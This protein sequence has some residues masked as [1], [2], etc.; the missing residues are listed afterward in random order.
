MLLQA[1]AEANRCRTVWSR[2]LGFSTVIG[3][4]RHASGGTAVHL[5]AVQAQ[6]ALQAAGTRTYGDGASRTRSFRQSFLTAYATRIDQRLKR[7]TQRA[8]EAAGENRG[9]ALPSARSSGHPTRTTPHPGR[10][11]GHQTSPRV[12]MQRQPRL[13]THPQRTIGDAVHESVIGH[14]IEPHP[15]TADWAPWRPERA[16]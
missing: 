7:A 16:A 12:S 15:A 9:P 8:A 4:A 13:L 10:R 11:P 2:N 6:S 1:V 14:G 5:A 3:F